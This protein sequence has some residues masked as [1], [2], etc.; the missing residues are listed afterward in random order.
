MFTAIKKSLVYICSI[1]FTL[2]VAC[3]YDL[4]CCI[5][6]LEA[7]KIINLWNKSLFELNIKIILWHCIKNIKG[8]WIGVCVWV[9]QCIIKIDFLFVIQIHWSVL[10]IQQLATKNVWKKSVALT[11]NSTFYYIFHVSFFTFAFRIINFFFFF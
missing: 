11:G 2:C 10:F 3:S 9:C 7:M 5:R 4:T 8:F 6:G 1:I